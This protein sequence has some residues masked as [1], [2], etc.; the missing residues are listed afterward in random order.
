MKESNRGTESISSKF[1]FLTSSK[2]DKI[3]TKEFT[4]EEENVKLTM[5]VIFTDLKALSR[6]QILKF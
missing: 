2:D 3:F 6:Q 1:F 4:F 5:I